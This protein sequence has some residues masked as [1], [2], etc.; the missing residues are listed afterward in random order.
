MDC[1]PSTASLVKIQIQMKSRDK[2]TE[3]LSALQL[4]LTVFELHKAGGK[5]S[6]NV[7][8]TLFSSASVIQC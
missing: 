3:S 8:L 1:Q 7:T 4:F 2:T 5:L 6:F